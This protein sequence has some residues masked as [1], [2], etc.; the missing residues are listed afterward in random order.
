M[1]QTLQKYCEKGLMCC[2]KKMGSLMTFMRVFYSPTS[3]LP[4]FPVD[5]HDRFLKLKNNCRSVSEVQV[6]PQEQ[7]M[8]RIGR[9][10][11]VCIEIMNMSLLKGKCSCKQVLHRNS[12][13]KYICSS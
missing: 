12:N 3:G 13:E 1:K 4:F 6:V 10:T 11:N 2:V 9:K 8:R 7:K 5:F